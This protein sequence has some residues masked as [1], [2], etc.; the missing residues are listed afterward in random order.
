MDLDGERWRVVQRNRLIIEAC[1]ACWMKWPDEW[2]HFP[3]TG[4]GRWADE[5]ASLRTRVLY[6]EQGELLEYEL[7]PGKPRPA[8]SDEELDRLIALL[9]ETAP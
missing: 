5:Q 2:K 1:L 8:L 4:F 9:L 3:A 6:D 7:L